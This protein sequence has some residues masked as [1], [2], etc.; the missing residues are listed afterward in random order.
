MEEVYIRD[1]AEGVPQVYLS[2][3]GA[4]RVAYLPASL[5]RAFHK[6]LAHDHFLLLAGVLEWARAAERD[7]DVSGA[8]VIEVTGWHQAESM[9]VFL[10]NHTNPMYLKGPVHELLPSASQHVRI[11]TP[12]GRLVR[13]VRLLKCPDEPAFAFIDGY[14]HLTVEGIEDFEVVAID[15]HPIGAEI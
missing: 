9:T 11:K 2:R 1:R 6:V 15:L 12:E 8:G 10:V 14:V 5:D 7:I 3:R 4:G 13:G